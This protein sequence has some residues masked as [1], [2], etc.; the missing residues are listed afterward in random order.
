M[1]HY[2]LGNS[3]RA[4]LQ[5]LSKPFPLKDVAGSAYFQGTGSLNHLLMGDVKVDWIKLRG[6]PTER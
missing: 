6:V 1:A 4:T 3:P 2:K 5:T